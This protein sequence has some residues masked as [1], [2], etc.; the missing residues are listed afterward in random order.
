MKQYFISDEEIFEVRKDNIE[1]INILL[2]KFSNI[3]DEVYKKF[4]FFGK[5]FFL[6][7][8]RK[9]IKSI[10]LTHQ[11]YN[12]DSNS[13]I[14][15][16]VKYTNN[17]LL[18]HLA[19]N[20]Y[21]ILNDYLQFCGKDKL[22]ETTRFLRK[23]GYEEDIDTT[24]AIFDNCPAI[25]VELDELFRDVENYSNRWI[26]SVSYNNLMKHFIRMYM[27]KNDIVD[28]SLNMPEENLDVTYDDSAVR[29][30]PSF[31]HYLNDIGR[32]GMKI[33]SPE[34]EMDLSKAAMEGNIEARNTLVEA[35]LK[36]VI[37]VARCYA[38]K[39]LPFNDLVQ[40]GNM[41]LMKAAIK[42]DYRKGFRFTTYAT[43]W[44]RQA[45][46][47]DI[48]NQGRSIRIPIHMG[49]K[50]SATRRV[51]EQFKL[52]NGREPNIEELAHLLD[53][54]MDKVEE[55][56]S[57]FEDAR[58]LNSS[59]SDE[60][61]ESE[62]ENF[63]ADVHQNVE[64]M[65]MKSILSAEVLNLLDQANLS[66]QEKKVLFYR[67][68]FYNDHVY[69]LSEVAQIFNLS[70]ERIRQI[71]VKALTKL[72]RLRNIDSYADVYMDNPD[73]AKRFRKEQIHEKK[74]V[75]WNENNDKKI[76][77][78]GENKMSRREPREVKNLFVYLEVPEEE[79]WKVKMIVE[80]FPES[81]QEMFYKKCGDDLLG[82]GV[83]KLAKEERGRFYGNLLPRIG[84]YY[85]NLRRYDDTNEFAQQLEKIFDKTVKNNASFSNLIL[86]FKSSF[87]F[88]EITQ[89]MA[90]LTDE[91]KQLVYKRFGANLTGESGIKLEKEEN[92]VY[93]TKILPK[94]KVRLRNMYPDR[95][96]SENNLLRNTVVSNK[97]SSKEVKVEEKS[98]TFDD[99]L[100]T[101][102]TP[103]DEPLKKEVQVKEATF[104]ELSTPQLSEEVKPAFNLS[105][106][107]QVLPNI[108]QENEQSNVE[109]TLQSNKLTADDFR[110]LKEIL[111]LDAFKE[112]TKVGFP[113]EQVV[114]VSMYHGY[115]NRS[116]TIDEISSIL[117]IEKEVVK[118]MI[119]DSLKVYRSL[120]D[121]MFDNS[122]LALKKL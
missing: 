32:M 21:K 14:K 8:E 111:K 48:G 53:T 47:R 82:T 72:R 110:S 118:E 71:E 84:R 119:I 12:K 112:L 44:I 86:Y 108:S 27:L 28:E 63:V 19:D 93:N 16:F 96:S 22:I 2:E 67:N 92:I 65:G 114:V 90:D 20:N 42:Y 54:T 79:Q 4:K 1:V 83:G 101:G 74:R 9:V 115:L 70:R 57:Y 116:F 41:G 102:E 38:G 89:A 73:E 95:A 39:G 52:D 11:G 87:T 98:T 120:T 7:I 97:E 105:N 31:T 49:V 61:E 33:L 104:V 17:F 55:I 80:K 15:D 6:Q 68:G 117:G 76:Y 85:D 94:I 99:T 46:L 45:I 50:V 5:E 58:S 88:E 121:Q 34:E 107:E 69:T 29:E 40:S 25:V 100:R 51:I 75:K 60:D 36:Y 62:L 24:L 113:L 18:V 81:D 35:N 66:Q 3:L 30:L 59:I 64:E 13:V 91:E 106:V 10:C 37:K 26:N 122:I 77:K 78:K 56:L 43:W 23:I 109:S 103:M